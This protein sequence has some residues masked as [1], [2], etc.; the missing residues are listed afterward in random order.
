[1]PTY[2]QDLLEKRLHHK[3]PGMAALQMYHW[4]DLRLQYIYICVYIYGYFTQ[5][6][7]SHK[8]SLRI[9]DIADSDSLSDFTARKALGFNSLPVLKSLI[10]PSDSPAGIFP[11]SFPNSIFPDILPLFHLFPIKFPIPLPSFS[12]ISCQGLDLK[13]LV[14]LALSLEDA[15]QL[16]KTKGS[17]KA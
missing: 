1:M 6:R 17:F 13:G 12:I 5:I 9:V 14:Q 3:A 2:L 11:V 10:D 7:E 16:R 15:K 4:V 8:I